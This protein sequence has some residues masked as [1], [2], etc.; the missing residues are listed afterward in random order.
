[1]ND[2]FSTYF[3]RSFLF[4]EPVATVCHVF[5]LFVQQCIQYM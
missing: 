3:R 4:N 2:I 1:M 5:E